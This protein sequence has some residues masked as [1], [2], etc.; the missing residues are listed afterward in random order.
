LA[1]HALVHHGGIVNER[2][3]D[4]RRLLHIVGLDAVVHVFVAVMRAAAVFDRVLDELEAGQSDRIEADVIGRAG[5]RNRDGLRL[6]VCE[7]RKPFLEQ[8]NG[9]HG[10]SIIEPLT[11]TKRAKRAAP[12]SNPS[13]GVRRAWKILPRQF[14]PQLDS[15]QIDQAVLD[16]AYSLEVDLL[17]AR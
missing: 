4:Y 2:C 10:P 8:R 14:R 15:T 5:V 7:R 12:M 16:A 13:R 1:G 6:E 11:T 3:H 17:R 9:Q